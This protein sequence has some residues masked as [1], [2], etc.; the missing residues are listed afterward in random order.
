MRTKRTSIATI[1]VTTIALAFALALTAHQ[2]LQAADD[3]IPE[4]THDGLQ[5][6]EDSKAAIAYVKPGADL[7]VYDRF[8]IVDCFVAF[9]KDWQKDY[10][11]D[12]RSL[13]GQVTDKDM[14]RMRNDMAEL[15]RE[16][17]VEELTENDGYELVDA[18]A[19]G[20]LLIRPAIID[21]EA[22]APDVQSAGRSTTFVDS[23]GTATLF[24]ELYD[25][26]SGEILARAI[27][28]KADR[29]HG[30]MEWSTG[31]SNRVNA[32]RILRTWAGW[33]RERMDEVHARG[34]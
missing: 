17:F 20:V 11:R 8:L 21:L 5:R 24:I 25:S 9:K 2:D 32:K 19:E 10:N 29:S 3:D 23:A 13:S 33:L 15:F 34:Q 18:P 30:R 4:V 1:R 12:Q 28:R 16:V 27:D 14:E 6:L 22:T 26:V 31:T 7:S